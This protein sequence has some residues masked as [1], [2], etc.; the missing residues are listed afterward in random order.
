MGEKPDTPVEKIDE[1]WQPWMILGNAHAALIVFSMICCATVIAV[2]M[3]GEAK[4]VQDR[5]TG[6]YVTYVK[7]AAKA[8]PRVAP[9][10]GE[11]LA[12]GRVTKSELE[13]VSTL[14]DLA[15]AAPGGLDTCQYKISYHN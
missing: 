8:C 10:M 11:F 12:N 7:E 2:F 6:R 14:L 1:R 13:V 5:E 9:R 4:A 15:R 3:S